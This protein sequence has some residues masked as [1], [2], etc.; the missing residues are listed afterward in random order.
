[1]HTVHI[2]P[3]RPYRPYIDLSQLPGK[4]ARDLPVT[5]GMHYTTG[6]YNLLHKDDDRESVQ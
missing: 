6:T 1:M 5:D 2:T 3:D 4:R